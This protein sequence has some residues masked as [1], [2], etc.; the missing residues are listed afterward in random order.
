MA[1]TINSLGIGSG[2]LTSDLLDQLK[3]NDRSNIVTPI[4]NSIALQQQKGQALDL[5]DSLLTSFQSNVDALD[6][7]VL[8]Q[9]RSV[10]GNNDG[11]NVTAEAGV[12]IQSFSLDVTTL[13]KS[14]VQQSGEFSSETAS[15]SSGIGSLNLN[16]NGTNHTID[17]EADTTLEELKKAINDAAGDNVTASVL[18]TGDS[19]FSL[20]ITS[21]NTGNDQVISLTDISGNL[22]NKLLSDAQVSGTFATATADAASATGQMDIEINGTHYQVDYTDSSTIQSIADSINND[23]TLNSIVSAS[24]VKYADNDYRMVLT[25]KEGTQDQAITVTDLGTG[26]DANL[27]NAAGTAVNGDMQVIQDGVDSSFKFNGITM[28]RSSN[29]ITDIQLG[30]TVELLKEGESANIAISQDTQ[31]VADELSG[32]ATSYNTLMKQLDDMTLTDVD[33]GKVGIFNG[34][35]TIKNIGREIT[36]V[37]TSVNSNGDSLAQFGISL[38]QDGTMSFNQTE[39]DTKFDADTDAAEL[40][41]SG[42]SEVDGVFS[43]LNNLLEGYVGSSGFMD[44]LTTASSSSVTSLQEEYTKALDLLNTRYDTMASRFI[45]YDAIISR[46]NNQSN[47]LIQ[48][49]DM[50]LAAAQG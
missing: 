27:L 6:Y 19:A 23:T 22:D 5:L 3:E 48:Q 32:L 37:I 8:Y 21:D 38:N 47:A 35:N 28:T 44:T 39:F 11:V 14:N 10:S 42:T 9:E 15:V 18:Q 45:A 1:G 29:T 43:T 2:V 7:D 33:A 41:F 34:D 16:I 24:V 20:V 25:P 46:L 31:K 50:A 12:S 49:I 4:E 36:R 30:L 26:L 13:A 40:F 17:Y